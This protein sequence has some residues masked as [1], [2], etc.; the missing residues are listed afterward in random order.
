MEDA[1][2]KNSLETLRRAF[3]D[4][5]VQVRGMVVGIYV[6]LGPEWWHA[7][8]TIEPDANRVAKGPTSRA[9]PI[10]AITRRGQVLGPDDHQHIPIAGNT[11]EAVQ[12][13]RVD[14]ERLHS[15]M[16]GPAHG[17]PSSAPGG[18][19]APMALEDFFESQ[20]AALSPSLAKSVF[21]IDPTGGKDALDLS[22][23]A[24]VDAFTAEQAACLWVGADP[25]RSEHRRDEAEKRRIEPIK[26]MIFG[27]IQT[28]ELRADSSTNFMATVGDFS[29]SLIRREDLRALAARKDQRP[30][31]LFDTLLPE[32]TTPPTASQPQ[33]GDPA[34][35][36][37]PR[38]KGGRPREYDWDA[39]TIEIIRIADM[40]RLPEKQSELIEQM[41]QWCENTWGRQ[42]AESSVKSRI[43]RIYNGLGRGQKPR[44]V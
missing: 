24:L 28:G 41:L 34:P 19:A 1:G 30:A 38:A 25:S 27:A 37:Q 21:G 44:G 16:R 32:S 17:W 18:T 43:S 40:D 15:V 12:V 10:R 31:F 3:I 11:A 9:L 36:D 20:L 33:S 6:P 35:T 14:L 23:W 4:R 26:Q 7:G 2:E 13:S 29:K 39:F 8:A 42:P 5:K 22:N